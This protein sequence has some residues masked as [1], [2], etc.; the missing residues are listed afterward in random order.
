[1][2]ERDEVYEEV[3]AMTEEELRAELEAEGKTM[4][5]VA[6]EM[7]AIFEQAK[8]EVDMRKAIRAWLK[9]P[10]DKRPTP[11][12]LGQRIADIASAHISHVGGSDVQP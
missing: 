3:M 8:A 11:Q 7:R 12:A 6:A 5:G 1:M 10:P 9:C 4:E 2:I